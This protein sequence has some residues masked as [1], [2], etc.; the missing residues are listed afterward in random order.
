MIICCLLML[1]AECDYYLARTTSVLTTSPH[2][3]D[4]QSASTDCLLKFA[5]NC[6]LLGQTGSSVQTAP[7]PSANCL[8][9]STLQVPSGAQATDC[10]VPG[11][12]FFLNGRQ[13]CSQSRFLRTR[14]RVLR[15]HNRV[16]RIKLNFEMRL[17]IEQGSQNPKQ[18][19]QNPKQGSQNPKTRFLELLKTWFLEPKTGFLEPWQVDSQ[20]PDSWVLRTTFV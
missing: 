9:S 18:G 10:H 17:Q 12:P 1:L 2:I 11:N 14:S 19:S 6:E 16:L 7:H 20:N 4:D 8:A 15:T 5:P 3:T 13:N